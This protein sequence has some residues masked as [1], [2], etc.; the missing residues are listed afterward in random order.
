[1][2]LADA[3]SHKPKGLHKS[4]ELVLTLFPESSIKGDD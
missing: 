3:T 4:Q 2:Y 1:M